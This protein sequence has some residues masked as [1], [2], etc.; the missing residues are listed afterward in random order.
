MLAYARKAASRAF[1]PSHGA[2]P[3]CAL[4]QCVRN[5]AVGGDRVEGFVRVTVILDSDILFGQA[6]S[7]GCRSMWHRSGVRPNRP[8][9]RSGE[10]R[11]AEERTLSRRPS[12]CTPHV[13]GA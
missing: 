8:V 3:A 10:Q 6:S 7:D 9:G 5:A 12:H 13:G 1:L 11:E 4:D 2:A